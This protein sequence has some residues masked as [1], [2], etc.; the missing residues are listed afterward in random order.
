MKA[1]RSICFVM[2]YFALVCKGEEEICMK[3]EPCTITR[4]IPFYQPGVYQCTINDELTYEIDTYDNVPEVMIV[5]SHSKFINV[6]TQT[7]NGD[8]LRIVVVVKLYDNKLEGEWKILFG[9]KIRIK[10]RV[11][12]T[13]DANLRRTVIAYKEFNKKLN[14]L[15]DGQKTLEAMINRTLDGLENAEYLIKK[16]VKNKETVGPRKAAVKNTDR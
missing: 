3:N 6:T 12:F 16:Q 10:F 11:I 7:I 9:D 5:D 4:V 13:D 2:L 15:L 1:I 8:N 14:F